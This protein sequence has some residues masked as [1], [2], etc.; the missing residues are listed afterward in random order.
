[1]SA[2][3]STSKNIEQYWSNICNIIFDDIDTLNAH[4]GMEYSEI[5]IHLQVWAIGGGFRG[6]LEWDIVVLEQSL[7][8]K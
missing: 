4:N 6:H 5:D 8:R 7:D 2:S 1:M 3:A